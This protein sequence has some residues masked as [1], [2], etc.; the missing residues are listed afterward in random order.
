MSGSARV[1]VMDAGGPEAVGL[2]A[3]RA[4]R[5]GGSGSISGVLIRRAS[6]AP[7][8]A[9]DA[10][11]VAKAVSACLGSGGGGQKRARK[12]RGAGDDPALVE[13]AS[14]G[15][16]GGTGVV[17]GVIV[18]IGRGSLV[19][20]GFTLPATICAEDLPSAVRLSME[21][22]PAVAAGT[23]VVDFIPLGIRPSEPGSESEMGS[24]VFSVLAAAVPK[25]EL[26]GVTAPVRA[27]GGKPIGSPMRSEGLAALVRAGGWK[28]VGAWSEA[29]EDQV[30]EPPTSV[31]AGD[32]PKADAG[33]VLGVWC[34]PTEVEFVVLDSRGRLLMARHCGLDIGDRE[35]A[36]RRAATEAKRTWM[37]A[38]ATPGVPRIGRVSVVGGGDAESV[39]VACGESIGVPSGI[40]DLGG[41]V[42]AGVGLDIETLLGR[43]APAVGLALQSLNAGKRSGGI[44]LRF[45]GRAGG[46]AGAGSAGEDLAGFDFLSP[47][48]GP[49]RSRAKRLALLAAGFGLVL[50]M[51]LVTTLRSD[52]QRREDRLAALRRHGLE[53]MAEYQD[54]MRQSAR[55]EHAERF[56]SSSARWGP[57]LSSLLD[58]LPSP[59]DVLLDRV[60]CSSE[61]EVVFTRGRDGYLASG[62]WSVR[63][64]VRFSLTGRSG[65]RARID[66]ARNAIVRDERYTL[67]TR[68]PDVP[69]NFDWVILTDGGKP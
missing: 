51:G 57:T 35:I 49:D 15:S 24:R 32:A 30:S 63:T 46:V 1:T 67:V 44:N 39:A 20:K 26:D 58:G 40:V 60:V 33:S 11:G 16:S 5:L 29:S 4:G 45:R 2:V 41:L 12:M 19:L 65:S 7:V 34:G 22:Q 55:A 25:D 62:E 66:A 61:A 6:F 53:V 31:S 14:G 43:A 13:A 59:P 54:L 36:Y 48:A 17:G 52:L 3:T 23:A 42:E 9:R 8:A 21:R 18:P 50:M 47:R 56:V 69:G 27:C 68:G 37:T 64:P 28:G 10:A 38:L